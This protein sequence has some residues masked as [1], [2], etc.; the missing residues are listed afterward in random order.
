MNSWLELVRLLTAFGLVFGVLPYLAFAGAKQTDASRS[1]RAA[2]AFAQTAFFFQATGMVFGD[3]RLYLPGAAFA[4]YVVFLIAAA[5]FTRRRGGP[6]TGAIPSR[7][8]LYGALLEWLDRGAQAQPVTR[9]IAAGRNRLALP[10]TLSVLV[11]AAVT[12]LRSAEF[13]LQHLRMERIESYARAISLQALMRGDAWDHDA[14]VAL[15]APIAWAAGL[16][17]DSVVRFSG[18]LVAALMVIVTAWSALRWIGDGLGA[19]LASATLAV[20]CARTYLTPFEPGG[21]EWSAV[22]LMLAVGLAR[23]AKGSAALAAVT[24]FVIHPGVGPLVWIAAASIAAASLL[25][26]ALR[27]LPG[28]LTALVPACAALAVVVSVLVAGARPT[29]APLQYESAARVA[30][31]IGREFRTNDWIVVSPGFEVAQTFGRGW[32]AELAGFVNAHTEDQMSDPQFRLPYS[33]ASIFVF[34]EKRVLD[35]PMLSLTNDGQ[36]ASYYYGTKLGRASLEFRAARLL[37]A[38]RASHTGATSV[39][40]EDDDLIVYRIEQPEAT[41]QKLAAAAG[42][43]QFQ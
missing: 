20:V 34:I 35:Q 4:L 6:I 14:S 16:P 5:M 43:A 7:R 3:W 26:P 38:Y 18:A 33:A 40:H 42:A 13:A 32:H 8:Q 36:S 37:T 24:A 39:Y 1:R 25:I 9:W 31:R 41:P 30:H 2:V 21:P 10:V 29:T 22:L 15:L 19:I 17:A 12:A 27:S 28:S 11:I 23:D